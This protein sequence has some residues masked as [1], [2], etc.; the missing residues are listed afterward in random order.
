M[1]CTRISAC[2]TFATFQSRALSR[3]GTS[4]KSTV[5]L[6]KPATGAAI[7]FTGETDRVYLHTAATCQLV[8]PGRERTIAISK[9]GSLSTVVWN[10]W[11]AKSARMPDFGDH[12]W[13]EMVCIETANVG[14]DAVELAP[15]HGAFNDRRHSGASKRT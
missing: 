3:L 14:G 8:D 4:T 5:L 11:V 1:L 15:E 2:R 6:E 10:P 9:S 13:P 7:E 12:E